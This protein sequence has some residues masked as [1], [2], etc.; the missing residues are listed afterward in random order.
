MG[1]TVWQGSFGS[2]PRE[3]YKRLREYQDL[4]EATPDPFIRYDIPEILEES[5]KAAAELLNAPLDTI[6]FVQNATTGVNIVLN[7]L[8]WDDDCKDEI[9]YFQTIY[10]AC[11]KTIDRVVDSNGGRVASREIAIAYPCEDEEIVATFRQA[12]QESLDDGKRAKICVFDTVS[13]LPGV[14]FPFEDMAKA[15]RDLGVMS[16]VDGAQG[17]GQI[18][19]D[20]TALNP[21]F[22]VTNCHKW[23]H[24]PRSCAAFYVPLRNQALM[25]STLPTSHGYVSNTIRFNPLPPSAATKSAFVKNFDYVGTVDWSAYLCVKDAISWRK[26]VLGGEEAVIGYMQRLAREGGMRAAQILGTEI[27]ENSR[28]TLTRCAMVNVA[29]PLVVRPTGSL[30]PPGV[31]SSIPADEA[32]LIGQWMMEALIHEYKTFIVLYIH[33]DRIWARLSAQVYLDINDF[34]WA[35]RTLAE[36]CRRVADGEHL[37]RSS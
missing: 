22:L 23:L 7:N 36:L 33:R 25:A 4:T 30:L 18:T 19:I 32:A 2:S 35:G 24:V 15:C 14:R 16:L 28:G 29:L 11:A 3:V 9:L 26:E 1:L 10:G 5:R 21:D 34:E 6:V 31:V 37:S 13:S 27:M 20:L 8:Q 17:V 12:V